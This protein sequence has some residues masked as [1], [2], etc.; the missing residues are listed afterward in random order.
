MGSLVVSVLLVM[1]AGL[2]FTRVDAAPTDISLSPSAGTVST[3]VTVT[4][5]A[6]WPGLGVNSARAS[7]IGLTLGVSDS[8]IEVPAGG[9]WSTQFVVPTNAIEGPHVIAALCV[10]GLGSYTYLPLT[11]TVTAPPASSTTLAP[12]TT[13]A[14]TVTS[15]FIPTTT[16]ALEQ[17]G[18]TTTAGSGLGATTTT[19]A[20]GLGATTTTIDVAAGPSGGGGSNGDGRAPDSASGSHAVTTAQ[21]PPS[22]EAAATPTSIGQDA[23]VEIESISADRVE[24]GGRQPLGFGSLT[25]IGDGWVGLLVS[26]L[27]AMLIMS[28]VLAVAWFAWLRHTDARQWWL[29]WMHQITDIRSHARPR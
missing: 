24:R 2:I 28:G 25:P 23:P 22:T 17:G 27:I 12:S 1:T 18:P 4:G 3:T 9:A 21:L 19:A 15:T 14:T 5:S 6:C 8:D 10:A 29:R 13:V 11:F 7:V 20:G 26:A 16:A